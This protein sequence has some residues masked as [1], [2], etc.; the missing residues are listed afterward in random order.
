[1]FAD[2]NSHFSKVKDKRC[3]AVEVN[4]DLKIISNYSK[5]NFI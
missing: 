2:E 5:K 3:S 4:N 1:M